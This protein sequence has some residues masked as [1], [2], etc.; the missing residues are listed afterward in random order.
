MD[1]IVLDEDTSIPGTPFPK[2][3]MCCEVAA[4]NNLKVF[5]TFCQYRNHFNAYHVPLVKLWICPGCNKTFAYK[6]NLQAHTSHKQTKCFKK[7]ITIKSVRNEKY[8]DPEGISMPAYN[9]YDNSR[10]TKQERIDHDKK[11][12]KLKRDACR[13][14]AENKTKWQRLAREIGHCGQ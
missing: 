8:I 6:R 2:L 12:G 14:Y 3:G 5:R 1:E 9:T 4:C 11:C 10:V 13:E 7:P